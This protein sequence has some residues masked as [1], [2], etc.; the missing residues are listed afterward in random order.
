MLAR[1]KSVVALSS[2]CPWLP[3][4]VQF[5]PTLAQSGGRIVILLQNA[6]CSRRSRTRL[7]ITESQ[8]DVLSEKK[9]P[10]N[11]I[12]RFS[13]PPSSHVMINSCYFKLAGLSGLR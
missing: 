4:N 5:C 1:K 6:S 9:K 8:R 7:Q 3:R 11:R 10:L 2:V 13:D 12:T